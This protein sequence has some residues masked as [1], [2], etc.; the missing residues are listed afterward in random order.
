MP[1]KSEMEFTEI[2]LKK[3]AE[4]CLHSEDP[5]EVQRGV[6]LATLALVEEIQRV[7][8][9]LPASEDEKTEKEPRFVAKLIRHPN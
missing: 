4:I 6:G 8:Q 3:K 7:F 1:T 5:T 9:S 2:S